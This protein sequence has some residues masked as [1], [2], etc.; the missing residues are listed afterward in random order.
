MDEVV[1]R[2]RFAHILEALFFGFLMKTVDLPFSVCGA[3][4]PFLITYEIRI[5]SNRELGATLLNQ[6]F[7]SECLKYF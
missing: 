7:F 4:L 1:E 5:R 3:R 2:R 6:T